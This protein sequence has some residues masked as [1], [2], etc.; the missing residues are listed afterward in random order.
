M[1]TFNSISVGTNCPPIADDAAHTTKP[2]KPI[3]FTLTGS[4]P[5]N[6]PNTF[7][8]FTSRQPA[9]G[10]LDCLSPA[11]VEASRCTYTPNEGFTGVDTFTFHV[12]DGQDNSEDATVTITVDDPCKRWKEEIDQL[13]TEHNNI[14]AKIDVARITPEVKVLGN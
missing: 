8:Q 6:Q 5:D 3:T 7:L 2:G 14:V 11:G 4:D 12:Y 10:K 9:N 1:V 13:T